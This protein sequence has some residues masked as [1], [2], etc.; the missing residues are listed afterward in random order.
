MAVLDHK[1]DDGWPFTGEIIIMSNSVQC[2]QPD[3][4]AY[5]PDNT[6]LCPFLVRSRA[7]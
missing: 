6:N 5:K 4:E 3:G 7:R 2:N 1:Y